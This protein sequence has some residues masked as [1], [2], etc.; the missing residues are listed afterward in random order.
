VQSN[1]SSPSYTVDI[2]DLTRSCSNTACEH[3]FRRI[4]LRLERIAI[5]IAVEATLNNDWHTAM[6]R[7]YAPHTS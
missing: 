3:Y 1:A 6:M 7:K 5:A 4:N 2:E